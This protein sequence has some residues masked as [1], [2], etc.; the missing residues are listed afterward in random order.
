L[1]TAE[2]VRELL[3]YNPATGEFTWLKRTGRQGAGKPAATAKRLGYPVMGIDSK[4]YM[5]SR[6]AWLWMT[7]SFPVRFIDHANG[8]PGDTRWTNLREA[9][10]QQNNRN[11]ARQAN[12]TSGFKGVSHQAGRWR[13]RIV[14]DRKPI[15]LGMYETPEEAH[16]AYC[17]AAATLFG[18]FARFE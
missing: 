1:I 14:Q 7:G 6:I 2:R 10:D 16:A 9:T 8:D 3:D 17:N 4:V 13:A 12:N 11:K 18:E 5:A 15:S